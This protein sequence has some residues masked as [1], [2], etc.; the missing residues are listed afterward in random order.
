M[1][2]HAIVSLLPAAGLLLAMAMPALAEDNGDRDHERPH[3]SKTVTVQLNAVDNSGQSGTAK[4]TDLGD[5]KTKV[6]IM[7]TGMPAGAS[8][9]THI[10]EGSCAALGAVKWSLNNLDSGASSTT[11][12]KSLEDIL[13]E[14]PLAIHSHKSAA[15]MNVR[16]LCGDIKKPVK[17]A[18]DAACMKEAINDR[19]TAI[20][21][22][23]GRREEALKK[24]VTDRKTALMA[25][26]DLEDSKA[27]RKALREAWSAYFK[28]RRDTWRSWREDRRDAWN[29][30]VKDRRECGRNAA[31]EDG[32]GVGHDSAL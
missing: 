29:Q 9:P 20:A 6:E 3:W 4:L 28:T 7:V 31:G 19:D 2:K 15:E 1:R 21:A 23:L 18:L 24:A 27:R 30:F 12:D 17:P 8:Q 26:W 32:T 14:L 25:A 13:K 22:A 5:D 11:L 16:V 10:H